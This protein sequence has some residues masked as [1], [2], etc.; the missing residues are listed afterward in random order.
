MLTTSGADEIPPT[1]QTIGGRIKTA[2]RIGWRRCTGGGE[3]GV[4]Q[5]NRIGDIHLTVVTDIHRIEAL[6]HCTLEQKRQTAHRIGDIE[7]AI[8]IRVTAN[9]DPPRGRSATIRILQIDEAIAIIIK[10][11]VTYL[12]SRDASTIG[13]TTIGQAI[14]VVILAIATIGFP[15]CRNGTIKEQLRV[16]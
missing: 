5:S 9:K 10:A 3:E 14:R 2:I 4:Q 1:M 11:V 12:E 6:H 13:I 8:P 15:P 16:R 7:I